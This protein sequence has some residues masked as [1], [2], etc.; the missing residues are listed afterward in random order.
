MR[1][2]RVDLRST[3]VG[4]RHF[5]L[6]TY[7]RTGSLRM[8]CAC[9]SSPRNG[10]RRTSAA[11]PVKPTHNCDSVHNSVYDDVGTVEP[12]SGIADGAIGGSQPHHAG[13]AHRVPGVE[14]KINQC[15]VEL[16]RVYVNRPEIDREI[17]FDVTRTLKSAT[18]Q[19]RGP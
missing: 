8:P 5:D 1:R 14:A 6:R 15:Q 9:L 17:S 2:Q 10:G 16:G 18:H 13:A 7:G 3:W 4:L 19:L 12:Q 11:S